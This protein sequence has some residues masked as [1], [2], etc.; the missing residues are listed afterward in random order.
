MNWMWIVILIPVVVWI[1]SSVIRPSEEQ[2][3]DLRRRLP[4]RDDEGPGEP[5][6][7]RPPSEVE[8][9]LEEINRLRQRAAEQQKA[10][11]EPTAAPAP[12]PPPPPMPRQMPRPVP[13]PRRPR[14]EP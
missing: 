5:P 1:L 3:R 2:P 10:A 14:P 6:R 9:F 11:E 12:K 13:P 7:A 4:P 8:R